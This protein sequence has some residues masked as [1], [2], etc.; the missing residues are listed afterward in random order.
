M[1]DY[2]AKASG[3]RVN[4]EEVRA[5]AE[6]M[7][8]EG[9]KGIMLRLASYLERLATDYDTIAGMKFESD[10]TAGRQLN[11]VTQDVA[12]SRHR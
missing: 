1:V 8:D 6:A 11:G 12:R 4:A 7:S 2:G 10:N 5:R 9:S 3:Y